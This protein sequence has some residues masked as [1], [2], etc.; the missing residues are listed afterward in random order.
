LQ[1]YEIRF[2]QLGNADLIIDAVYQGGIQGNLSDDPISKLIGCGTQGGFRII[3]KRTNTY[4]LT[5]LYSSMDDPDWPDY[6]DTETGIFIY[7]GDNKKP[8][9]ELHSKKGNVLLK[10]VF[11]LLHSTNANRKNIPPFFVFN[12]G[13]FGRNVV[14]RGLAVPGSYGLSPTDDLTAIWKSKVGFRFQNYKSIFTILD[15]PV[16][17]RLWINDIKN[18]NV[19]SENCPG[20][21]RYWVETGVY[22][23]LK[24]PK[25]VEYRSKKEQLP[26]STNNKQLIEHIY[27][28]FKD[29]PY[30]FEK[31]TVEI[32]R[33]MDKNIINC[34]LTRRWMDGG[35]DATGKY[36]IGYKDNAISVDFALEAKCYALDNSVKIG[37]TSRLISRLRYRQFGILV[38]TSFV[39]Q[40]AYK[41][42]KE[43][44]HPVVIISAEDIATILTE[45]GL[46]AKDV[47]VEWLHTNFPKN[48]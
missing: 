40:Q 28:Y 42:I 14:F 7:Y 22:T 31:C 47:L 17:K 2:E 10:H 9:H 43:D 30:N 41:E 29:D 33:F 18:G 38:T 25:N 4:K 23:P 16:I 34:D 32:A 1:G 44:G 6:L 12:K 26:S 24:A 11:D 15:I 21:W 36:R 37:H 35:R 45:A 5:V 20:V 27:N 8:G 46:G 13:G 48:I 3:G 39:D 19:F